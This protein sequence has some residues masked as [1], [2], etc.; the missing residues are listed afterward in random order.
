[1]HTYTQGKTIGERLKSKRLEKGLSLEEIA[2]DT[3]ISKERLDAIEQ[4]EFNQFPSHV[5][6]KGFIK[7][8]AKYL[9]IDW[10][11]LIAVY[12]R[13]IEKI[14]MVRVVKKIDEPEEKK[15]KTKYFL[16]NFHFELTRK[17]LSL[18]LLLIFFGFVGFFVSNIVIDAFSEPHLKI[19]APITAIAPFNSSYQ[20][21]SN[22]VIIKGEAAKNSVVKI[23]DKIIEFKPG[24]I[25]ES[26]PIPIIGENNLVTITATS[27]LGVVSTVML[28]VEKGISGQLKETTEENIAI[29]KIVNAPTF[30]IARSDGEVKYNSDALVNETFSL[31]VKNNFEIETMNPSNVHVFVN[32][33]EITLEKELERFERNGKDFVRL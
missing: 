7:N 32:N 17:S 23:N 1:V 29:V 28:K 16:K 12:R 9:K 15:N 24:Y 3:R 25:F 6:A 19:T 4:N 31:T 22:T 26:E 18:G 20:T 2:Y 14:D 8:Y 11:P 33:Q 21:N 5:Y 10:E 27:K 13:D 30:L